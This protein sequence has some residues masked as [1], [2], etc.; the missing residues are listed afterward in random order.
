M[1]CQDPC[2]GRLGIQACPARAERGACPG[3]GGSLRPA[4]AALSGP[5]TRRPQPSR[6]ASHVTGLGG[7]ESR[8]TRPGGA[9]ERRAQGS[10]SGRHCLSLRRAR[11]G[12]EAAV[13]IM[14]SSVT[15]CLP[16]VPVAVLSRHVSGC[17]EL[18]VTAVATVTA[19]LY[20][21]SV[22]TVT[23]RHRERNRNMSDL[24]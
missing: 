7:H 1:A 3:R 16:S 20:R 22:Q 6:R 8:L 18:D 23:R 5:G 12:S 15:F 2:P 9:R 17:R 4:E 19:V 13:E 11:P 21:A 10:A 24:H 14:S